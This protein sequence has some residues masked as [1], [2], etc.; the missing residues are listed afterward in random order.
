MFRPPPKLRGSGAETVWQNKMRDVVT[1]LRPIISRNA[2][3]SHTTR[4]VVHEG[5][6]IE[7]TSAGAAG[8]GGSAV[9]L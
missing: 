7:E 1:S 6:A 3:I 5:S 8:A 2:K 4:G 9:W